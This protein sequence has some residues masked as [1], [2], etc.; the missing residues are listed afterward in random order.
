MYSLKIFCFFE[1]KKRKIEKEIKEKK[2]N[3]LF[4]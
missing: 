3:L 4:V 2:K 1:K